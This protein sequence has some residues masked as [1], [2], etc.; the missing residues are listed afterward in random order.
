MAYDIGDTIRTSA[1]FTVNGVATDPTTVTATVRSPSGTSTAYTWAGATVT[2]NSAGNFQLDFVV[3]EA[4][5]WFVRWVGTGAA[6][7]TREELYDVIPSGVLGG[8]TLDV[9]TLA[10]GR[11]AINMHASD[12][13]QD[14]EIAAYI[15]AV[16]QR[17]DQVVGPVVVRTVT[18]ET[19]DGIGST[20]QL[21]HYPV[22]TIT[23][24]TEY[25]GA[26]GT[27]LTAET[28]GA[29]TTANDYALDARYGILTRRSGAADT[30][31]SL[32]RSRVVVTYVAGRFATTAAVSPLFKT[33][34]TVMLAHIWRRE[35][36]SDPMTAYQR[37]HGIAIP[38]VV[39][40]LLGD[41]WR[42]PA[43]A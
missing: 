39:R 12:T 38:R 22:S 24:V 36:S 4:G 11:A 28:V 32:G 41:E 33:A 27:V 10:E 1:S 42:L 23:T 6:A 3:T 7:A 14:T 29:A 30:Y 5:R 17:L 40:D 25:V 34:A 16:S 19:H 15:T 35:Q 26:T 31:F 2:R 20:I 43:M 8:A 37:S 9:I 13:S 18:A 21:H